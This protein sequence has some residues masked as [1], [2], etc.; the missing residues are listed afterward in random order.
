MAFPGTKQYLK[1]PSGND[2]GTQIYPLG[3]RSCLWKQ[4]NEIKGRLQFSY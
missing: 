3:G 2:D 4:V 1:C